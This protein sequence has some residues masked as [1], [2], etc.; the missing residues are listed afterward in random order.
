MSDT[1]KTEFKDG[2]LLLTLN[3]PEKKNAFTKQQWHAAAAQLDAAREND[4]VIVVVLTG[5]GKDFSAGQDLSESGSR[6]DKPPYQVMEEAVIA[7]D[8][9]LIGAAKGVAVGG[10][11]TIL[12]HCDILYVG[13]SLRMRMPFV[14][15]GIAPEFAS[16][17]MLQ[18]N[19]GA[20]RAAE[21]M[22]TAEWI[23]ADRAVE[24]GIATRKYGDDELLR[25]AMAKAAEIAQW[26][27]RTLLD[28]KRCLKL[29]HKSGIETALKAER[30]SMVRQSGGPENTEAIRAFLEKRKPDFR[31]LKK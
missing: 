26:P 29:A 19:I 16:T 15:L 11:A 17:Y 1:V 27:V 25:N 4:D 21:L 10:G 20:R 28:A 18:A 30:E 24:T 31:N 3:R 7:F 6:G 8:K 9:P 22:F 2:I 12:F 23:D 5:A 13:E 14:T